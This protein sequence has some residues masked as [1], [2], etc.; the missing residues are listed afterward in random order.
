M[1]RTPPQPRR[2]GRLDG[3]ALSR[4]AGRVLA[5]L[6]LVWIAALVAW[7]ETRVRCWY[8]Q[9]FEGGVP[10]P[11]DQAAFRMFDGMW[12]ACDCTRDSSFAAMIGSGHR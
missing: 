5:G 1:E 2:A 9:S 8:C 12:D 3:A 4:V 7:P 6:A 11:D 10:G